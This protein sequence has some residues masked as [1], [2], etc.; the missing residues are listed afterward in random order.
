MNSLSIKP[1]SNILLRAR[2]VT[3]FLL[4][5]SIVSVLSIGSSNIKAMSSEPSIGFYNTNSLPAGMNSIDPLIENYWNW[6]A[7]QSSAYS[8]NWPPCMIG[9]ADR[10]ASNQSIIFFGD[11]ATAVELNVNAR[12]QHCQ[13][14]SN[15][16]IFFPPYNGLCNT[17]EEPGDTPDQL[18][19]CAIGTNKGIQLMSLKIDGKD[20]SNQIFHTHTSKPFIWDVPKDNIYA[21]PQSEPNVGS[22]PAMAEGYMYL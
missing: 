12:N 7:K 15:Q 13:I 21:F 1:S 17:G 19:K 8:Q 3:Y 11:P 20:V 9:Q 2:F 14:S 6:W 5:I 22:H 16:A 10:L 4:I 18:L